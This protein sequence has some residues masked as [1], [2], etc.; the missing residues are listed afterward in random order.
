LLILNNDKPDSYKQELVNTFLYDNSIKKYILGRNDNASELSQVVNIE[1]YVDDF[2]QDLEWRDK[3]VIRIADIDTN[4]I[5]ASCSLAIYPQSALNSLKQCGVKYI[6]NY[7]EICRYAN[8]KQLTNNFMDS[9]EKDLKFNFK[10]YE[11]LYGKIK[12]KESLNVLTNLLNFRKNKELSYLKEYRVDIV[13]QYFE[14]FLSLQDGEVFVDAGGYDGQTSLEFI[15]YCPRYKKIYLLEPSNKIL[16]KAKKNLTKF[17]NI[18]FIGKGLSNCAKLLKFDENSGSANRLTPTGD[19]DVAVDTLDNLIREKITF[20]KM[21]IE[22]SE[23]KAIE[24]ARKH[25]QI[26]HP[27]LAI[28]VYH[29]PDDFWKLAEQ[30]LA[31]RDDYT[32]YMRH[33]TEGT[34]E[35]VLFFIPDGQG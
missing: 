33:Y 20:I 22:G 10:K 31:I 15:R 13:G 9:A 28:S 12:E 26:D 19:V 4:S 18:S 25:I 32:L 11:D 17:S 1:A 7:L 29:K 35:T 16:K 24:G 21:D 34:D 2:T 3:P 14:D 23:G 6:L 8:H 27:K 30:V 5:V